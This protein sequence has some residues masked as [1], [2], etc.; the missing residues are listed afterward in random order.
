MS[1]FPNPHSPNSNDTHS[2]YVNDAFNSPEEL[3]VLGKPSRLL[4]VLV[5]ISTAV[6]KH[7][8]QKQMGRKGYLLLILPHHR[9]E[10]GQNTRQKLGG[11][12][13]KQNSW[14]NT[15]H[16]FTPHGLLSLLSH[17]TQDLLQ[18]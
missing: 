14:R 16:R 6:I 7:H 15:V 1:L 10:S 4:T 8:D 5:G 12:K 2:K 13:L 17:T 9:R 11:Q 18:E 3:T